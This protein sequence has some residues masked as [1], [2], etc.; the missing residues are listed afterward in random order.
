MSSISQIGLDIPIL[1]PMSD[2]SVG[3]TGR[4]SISPLIIA[5]PFGNHV[6]PTGTTPTLKTFTAK[7]RGGAANRAWR[8]Q[9]T[10]RSYPRM[11]AWINRVGLR[12]PGIHWLV[13]RV[14]RGHMQ[15][16]EPNDIDA[17]AQAGADHVAIATKLFNPVYLVSHRPVQPLI[18]RAHTRLG[19]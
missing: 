6:Q 5:A 16:Y 3:D 15:V 13:E 11:R 17:Y 12:H 9:K 7:R 14:Q 8:V 10:V 1:R 18:D 19:R 2:P 4:A